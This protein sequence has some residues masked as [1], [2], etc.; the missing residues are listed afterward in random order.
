LKHP[1]K[2]PIHL[3]YNNFIDLS[4]SRDLGNG[5]VLPH[6]QSRRAAIPW[7]AFVSIAKELELAEDVYAS[8]GPAAWEHERSASILNIVCSFVSLH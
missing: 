2:Y 7:D 6:F 3:S 5:P 4:D 1:D 8:V